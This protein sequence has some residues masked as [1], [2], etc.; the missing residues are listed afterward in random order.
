MLLRSHRKQYSRHATSGYTYAA[1]TQAGSAMRKRTS[2]LLLLVSA[3]WP[4]LAAAPW[5]T[6]NAKSVSIDQFEQLLNTLQGKSDGKVAHEISGVALANRV[7]PTQLARWETAFPGVHTHEELVKLTDQAD[8]FDP[9]GADVPRIPEPDEDT[10]EKMLSLVTDYVKTETKRLPNFSAKRETTH[11]EDEP[12]QL[13]LLR[14]RDSAPASMTL[15]AR[16]GGTNANKTNYVPLHVT[17]TYSTMVTYRDGQEVRDTDSE[18][19]AKT[20]PAPGGLYS[21]GEFGPILYVV[22]GDAFRSEVFWLRWEQ[23]PGDPAAVFR[24]QVP[25]MHSSFTVMISVGGKMVQL[26]PGYHGEIAI[27]PATGAVLRMSIVAAL[28]P[29]Y[30]EMQAA[31]TVEFAPVTIGDRTYIGPVHAVTLSK[32]PIPGAVGDP[33]ATTVTVQ[34]Q[35][36]DVTFTKYH[37]FGSEAHI[38][39]G[40]AKMDNTPPDSAGAASTPGV[41]AGAGTADSA[42]AGGAPAPA[43]GP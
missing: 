16:L 4:A 29:P 14:S 33:E 26:H 19:G 6:Q 15:Q 7:S 3:P 17:G 42:P 22:V 31:V 8:F 36:N 43:N 5:P 25:A 24:Y 35:L 20:G 34:T 9:P 28:E 1:V 30:Q 21:S 2:L 11:F 39:T 37:L 18:K 27:D 41:A 32:F 10:K 40:N 12:S 23:G 13:A 38:L